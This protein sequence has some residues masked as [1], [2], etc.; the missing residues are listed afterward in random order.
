MQYTYCTCEL[1]CTKM[2]ILTA[3]EKKANAY[4]KKGE[5]LVN[6][7]PPDCPSAFVMMHPNGNTYI[8]TNNNVELEEPVE[9]LIRVVETHSNYGRIRE[10]MQIEKTAIVLNHLRNLVFE[11]PLD[12][13]G[14]KC[15]RDIVR[16]IMKKNAKSNGYKESNPG[17]SDRGRRPSWWPQNIHW[18]DTKSKF[19][20]ECFQKII[21]ECFLHYGVDLV[22][23]ESVGERR[24]SHHSGRERTRPRRRRALSPSVGLSAS[25]RQPCHAARSVNRSRSPVIQRSTVRQTHQVVRQNVQAISTNA[26]VDHPRRRRRRILTSSSGSE[27]TSPV[28]NIQPATTSSVGQTIAEIHPAPVQCM[29]SV[30]GSPTSPVHFQRASSRSSNGSGIRI[31]QGRSNDSDTT[32][33][34]SSPSS[35]SSPIPLTMSSNGS[36]TTSSRSRSNNSD[37]ASSVVSSRSFNDSEPIDLHLNQVQHMATPLNETVARSRVLR[38]RIIPRSCY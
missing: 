29:S 32:G 12:E 17:Y 21:H 13:L 9:E 18:G 5:D 20:K 4:L 30:G 10:E 15:L 1:H 23:P 24:P 31:S 11:K 33:S 2:S 19:T 38:S 6:Y 36:D 37:T 8:Y 7:I 35:R 22:V 14:F 28:R 26:S 16:D 27:G 25:G 34:S 3:E